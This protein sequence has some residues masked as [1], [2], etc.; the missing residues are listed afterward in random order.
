M[1]LPIS[2]VCITDCNNIHTWFYQQLFE[3]ENKCLFMGNVVVIEVMYKFVLDIY[4]Y[5]YI[6]IYTY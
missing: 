5:M 6:C 2:K 1:L 3:S 4:T